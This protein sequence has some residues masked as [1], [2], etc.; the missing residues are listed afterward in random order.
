MPEN[1]LKHLKGLETFKDSNTVVITDVDGTLSEIVQEPDD[2]IVD[3]EMKVILRNLVN[4][5]QFL[6]FITG[7]TI[8]NV[9][10][11]VDIFGALYIG[12]HGM[13]YLEND[14]IVLG[15]EISGYRKEIGE[16]EAKLKN[17]L[18]LS[19]LI[20]ENK[21]TCLTIH[22][23]MNENQEM[24]RIIILDEIKKLGLSRDLKVSEGKKVIEIKPQTGNNKGTI[25][26][27][28][29]DDHQIHQLIYCG[30]DTTDVDAFEAIKRLNMKPSFNGISIAVLSNE[31][32]VNVV[33]TAQ[34]Y[35]NSIPEL[36]T[37]FNWLMD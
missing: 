34:Y 7:R 11:M 3:D 17:R 14:E 23:R 35:V 22:Y 24:A 29:V 10:K 27:R 12:N 18:N 15:P 9:R 16:I 21:K 32:P 6:I 1:I 37:F 4:K 5:F 28:M 33:N 31:T 36:K 26:R 20:F 19:G 8:R 25:I 13:E 30:D 2:A